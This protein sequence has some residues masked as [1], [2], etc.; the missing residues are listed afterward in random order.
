MAGTGNLAKVERL[1]KGMRAAMVV[2]NTFLVACAEAPFGDIDH[3]GMGRES[4]M[5]VIRDDQNTR[6]THIMWS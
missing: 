3:S 5:G 2:I 6:L 4:G 1:S